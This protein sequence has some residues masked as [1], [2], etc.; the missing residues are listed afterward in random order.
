[1]IDNL[2][3]DD[4]KAILLICSD[5]VAKYGKN[6]NLKP[7]TIAEWNKISKKLL[8]SPMKSPKAFLIQQLMSGEFIWIF[9]KM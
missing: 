4:S 8:D 2:L 3:N 1:L 5:I 9:Q 6:N 7:L